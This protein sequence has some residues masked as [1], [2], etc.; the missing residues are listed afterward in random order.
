M[1]EQA[2]QAQTDAIQQADS[3]IRTGT[4]ALDHG[5]DGVRQLRAALQ[6]APL[7]GAFAQAVE[8]ILGME[9]RLIVVGVGKSGHIGSKLAATFASTGTPAFF[10]HPSEASHGDLGMISTKDIILALSWSGQTAELRDLVGYAKRQRVT[11]LSITSGADSMLAKASDTALILPKAREACPLNLAPTTSTMMQ[12]AL[13]DALAMALLDARG[14]TASNFQEFHPGGKLGVS[15]QAVSSVMVTGEM[16]PTVPADS[17]VAAAIEKISSNGFGI[18]GILDADGGL[19]GV[20]TDGDLRRYMQA[21]A[22]QTVDDALNSVR[23]ADIMT[24]QPVMV[25]TDTM[26]ASVLAVMQEKKISAVFVADPE[27][28]GTDTRALGHPQPR[29]IITFMHLLQL[30]AV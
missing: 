25:G 5:L 4:E 7:R 14:F 22:E 12:L 20:I 1:N 24:R 10:V 11:L 13:G 9:G 6:D 23:A 26:V 19:M 29:G 30:G 17:T 21:R 3:Y 28:I 27:Q 2:T 15:L 18:V 8:T 16:L